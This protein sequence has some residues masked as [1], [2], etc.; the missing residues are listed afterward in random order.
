M[1]TKS[2]SLP[3]YAPAATWI[4]DEQTETSQRYPEVYQEHPPVHW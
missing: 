3:P 1:K 4:P 2:R